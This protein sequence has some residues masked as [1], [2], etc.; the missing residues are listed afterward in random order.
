MGTVLLCRSAAGPHVARPDRHH[1]V[2]HWNAASDTFEAT[3]E[4]HERA[5]LE[6]YKQFV[7]GLVD[8][9]EAEMEA[10]RRQ[11]V[12]FYRDGQ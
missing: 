12:E 7:Q 4:L 6:R 8:Q 1:Q 9:G 5:E 11:V 2:F 10:V 3:G